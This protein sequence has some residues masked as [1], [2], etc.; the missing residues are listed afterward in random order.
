MLET[1]ERDLVARS[2]AEA[3]YAAYARQAVG[4]IHPQQEQSLLARLAEAL[5]P[6]VEP[7]SGRDPV[8]VANAALAAW[9]VAEPGIRGPRL[10]ALDRDNGSV[11]LAPAG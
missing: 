10:R 11:T 1:P 6:V 4:P 8:E 9:E 7:G 3:I 2:L 5:R